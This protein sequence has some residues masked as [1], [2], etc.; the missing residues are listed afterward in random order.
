MIILHYTEIVDKA[1]KLYNV[2]QTFLGRIFVRVN[3]KDDSILNEDTHNLIRDGDVEVE[4]KDGKPYLL[5]PALLDD[6]A[7]LSLLDVRLKII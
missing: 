7:T 5:I 1:L 4:Y 2:G 3:V 6:G